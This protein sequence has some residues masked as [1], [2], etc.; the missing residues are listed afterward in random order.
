[1]KSQYLFKEIMCIYLAQQ[2]TQCV[3]TECQIVKTVRKMNRPIFKPHPHSKSRLAQTENPEEL[4]GSSEASAESSER[5]QRPDCYSKQGNS[6][7][8]ALIEKI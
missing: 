4:S 3:H 8:T 2:T 6:R 5:K 7:E 1:L